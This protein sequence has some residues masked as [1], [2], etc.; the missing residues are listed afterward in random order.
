[1]PGHVLVVHFR[2]VARRRHKFTLRGLR[3]HGRKRRGA[4]L[5]HMGTMGSSPGKSTWDIPNRY[6]H[7]GQ[8][9]SGRRKRFSRQRAAERHLHRVP[10]LC[11]GRRRGDR[12]RD[13]GGPYDDRDTAVQPRSL[14]KPDD[15]FSKNGVEIDVVQLGDLK[16]KRA[17]YPPG[18]RFSER[19]VAPSATVRSGLRPGQ[20]PRRLE[21][22]LE[23][24]D[25]PWRRV[26][27]PGRPRRLQIGGAALRA[28]PVRRGR[29]GGPPLQPAWHGE[30]GLTPRCDARRRRGVARAA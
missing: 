26:H 17:S 23:L 10:T 14:Y 27:D 30:G 22:R 21:R 18:W 19:M 12:S 20:H 7:G 11:D 9:P 15:H 3:V 4:W 1:M 25:R 28:H 13:D 5:G 8:T 24:R 29:L 6:Y 16:V 2:D